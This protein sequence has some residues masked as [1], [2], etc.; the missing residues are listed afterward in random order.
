MALIRRYEFT[1]FICWSNF[2]KPFVFCSLLTF[3]YCSELQGQREARGRKVRKTEAIYPR[4]VFPSFFKLR[5]QKWPQH[6]RYST[7]LEIILIWYFLFCPCTKGRRRVKI[8]GTSNTVAASC[9]KG[10]AFSSRSFKSQQV[11]TLR[12]AE[13]RQL[14]AAES[15]APFFFNRRFD[16]RFL[17][18]MSQPRNDATEGF[19]NVLFVY[20]LC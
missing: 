6:C 16:R 5:F 11:L 13:T 8:S 2:H 1:R 17:S 9:S 20:F 7:V 18:M 14:G 3:S 4:F 19:R 15:Q 12:H 10:P